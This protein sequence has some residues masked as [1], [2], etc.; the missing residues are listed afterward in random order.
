VHVESFVIPHV[1]EIGCNHLSIIKTYAIM[2]TFCVSAG[3][4]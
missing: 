1:N 3:M 4:V 2:G